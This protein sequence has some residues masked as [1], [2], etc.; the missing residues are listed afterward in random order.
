MPVMVIE[1][2][3]FVLLALMAGIAGTTSTMMMN[4]NEIEIYEVD[5]NSFQGQIKTINDNII[6]T[7]EKININDIKKYIKDNE[8][9][10]IKKPKKQDKPGKIKFTFYSKNGETKI[11]YEHENITD[12]DFDKKYIEEIFRKM[13]FHQQ[14]IKKKQTQNTWWNKFIDFIEKD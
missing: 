7:A 8:I 9:K 12:L 4:Y 10:E 6:F 5:N 13:E 1:K 14:E 11:E 2:S 3:L